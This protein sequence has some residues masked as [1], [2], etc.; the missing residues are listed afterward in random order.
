MHQVTGGEGDNILLDALNRHFEVRRVPPEHAEVVFGGEG[1]DGRAFP[2]AVTFFV[3]VELWWPKLGNF[4]YS[5]GFLHLNNPRY[6]RLPYYV[7]D[8]NVGELISRPTL[9][10]EFWRKIASFAASSSATPIPNGLMRG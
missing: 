8:V 2:K 4:D 6:Y 10:T 1:V 3:P 5:L 9:R 7:F